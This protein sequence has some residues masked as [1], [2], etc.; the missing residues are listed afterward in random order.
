[1][2]ELLTFWSQARLENKTFCV[3][4]LR[5][6]CI[7]QYFLFCGYPVCII[8][9]PV[10]KAEPLSI[11]RRR[12]SERKLVEKEWEDHGKTGGSEGSTA[13]NCHPPDWRNKGK[14]RF[15]NP[16]AW[17][18]DV[19]GLQKAEE[20]WDSSGCWYLWVLS[21]EASS[22]SAESNWIL[23]MIAAIRVKS[24]VHLSY[25]D[26]CWNHLWVFVLWI[27]MLQEY[28]YSLLNTI[29]QFLRTSLSS[30]IKWGQ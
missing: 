8:Q 28:V 14:L 24:T 27:D 22:R 12:I 15:S 30:S 5:E 16:E 11:F 1:M 29:V 17:M 10:R 13:S 2:N 18:R 26:S 4:R 19:L 25:R 9:G 20:G 7:N 6:K 23:E 21:H 3:I